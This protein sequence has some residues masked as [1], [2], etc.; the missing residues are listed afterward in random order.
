MNEN[1]QADNS[2]DA[3]T[4][5]LSRGYQKEKDGAR[6]V[7]HDAQDAVSQKAG[8]VASEAKDALLDQAAGKQKDFGASLQAFGGAMRAASDHLA[9]S[10]Q[11]R[12]ATMMLEA[13]GGLERLSSS[14]RSK[15]V[16]EVLGEL[17]SYGRNNTPALMVGSVIAGL[18]LGR[19]LKSSSTD[20]LSSNGSSDDVWGENNRSQEYGRSTSN[21]SAGEFSSDR[22][23]RDDE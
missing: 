13:A 5:E 21:P 8:E 7:L 9:N 4:D 3:A 11:R 18:A 22:R 2:L 12:A 6:K 23:G 1:P 19:F 14:L 17:R 10:D 20:D 15:P 16:E